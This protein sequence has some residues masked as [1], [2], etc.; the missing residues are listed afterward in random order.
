MAAAASAQTLPVWWS[1]SSQTNNANDQVIKTLVDKENNS[2]RI[3]I[4]VVGADTNTRIT[5][6]STVGAQ[7]WTVSFNYS[8][9][10]DVVSAAALDKDG[11]PVLAVKIPDSTRT[12]QTNSIL[13]KVNK[14]TGA[15]LWAYQYVPGT[16]S[17]TTA[18]NGKFIFNDL[19]VD[20]DNTIIAGTQN[21]TVYAGQTTAS[22]RPVLYRFNA[23]G[24]GVVW[25]NSFGVA[26][27]Q[28]GVI[29]KIK[30]VGNRVYFTGGS[31]APSGALAGWRSA[32]ATTLTA[33]D[34][35][36][37]YI[38]SSTPSFEQVVDFDVTSDSRMIWS[39]YATDD[40]AGL[41]NP[42]GAYG[43]ILMA[44]TT[45]AGY[46]YTAATEDGTIYTGTAYDPATGLV[47]R[48]I[49]STT[50]GTR[51]TSVLVQ[52]IDTVN[53]WFVDVS[54]YPLTEGNGVGLVL[55]DEGR[56]VSVALNGGDLTA[57]LLDPALG[58]IARTT[59]GAG[60]STFL[61]NNIPT[62]PSNI[63]GYGRSITLGGGSST[64][65]QIYGLSFL[66]GPNDDK[67]TKEDTSLT[68]NVLTNDTNKVGAV[69]GTKSVTPMSGPTA[70]GTVTL[71]ADGTL[72]YTPTA[73]Y[74]GVEEFTYDLLVDGNVV[75][76]PSVKITVLAVNDAP[77]AVDDL[78]GTVTY[79]GTTVVSPLTND[80]DPE[81]P[82]AD[83][84]ISSVADFVNCEVRRHSD[85]KRVYVKPLARGPFSFTYIAADPS[86]AKSNSATVSGTYAP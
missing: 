8:A 83:L 86:G 42:R 47:Y 38:G 14:T 59:V 41:T 43:Q 28:V 85:R 66:A 7:V 30:L 17:S 11:N 12:Q 82:A 22:A 31:T 10:G 45:Y 79:V 53:N 23:A 13:L 40:A 60:T 81:S 1:G 29:S 26:T 36:F 63:G 61:P 20:T 37:G 3:G 78:L 50:P 80:T 71:L 5:K 24:S 56:V 15:A 74:S 33:S 73:D 68:F 2:Y 55:K 46:R 34:Y 21:D 6:Y 9:L 49:S 76:S 75:K 25:G 19:I 44:G 48:Q 18:L 54:T 16:G 64:G 57:S 70:H 39:G 4:E 77:V 27:T 51:G 84:K 72:T 52:S 58:E 67:R 69:F 32:T 35:N 65:A 62:S